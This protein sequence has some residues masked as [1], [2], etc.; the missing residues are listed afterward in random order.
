MAGFQVDPDELGRGDAAVAA[1]CAQARAAV[2]R[3]RTGADALFG[4][5][6]HGPAAA[7][8]RAGWDHWLAGTG[9]MLDALDGLA[10]LLGAAGTGYAEAEAGVRAAVNGTPA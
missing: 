2:G 4:G 10:A 6:W 5:G 9:E 8:F 1:R 3:I 7:A